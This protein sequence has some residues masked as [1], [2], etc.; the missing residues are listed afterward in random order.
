M[1]VHTASI[2]SLTWMVSA[3]IRKISGLSFSLL[4]LYMHMHIYIYLHA[5]I[6]LRRTHCKQSKKAVV[7]WRS[8]HSSQGEDVPSQPL[9]P[10]T[11]CRAPSDLIR[12]MAEPYQ[13]QPHCGAWDTYGSLQC[14]L[15]HRLLLNNCLS[16][17]APADIHTLIYPSTGVAICTHRSGA[18]HFL[19]NMQFHKYHK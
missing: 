7:L 1:P 11:C 16:S 18:K 10:C 6:I 9:P 3:C 2:W 12:A 13:C 8:R 14:G 19:E 17:P 15:W 5:A 4:S